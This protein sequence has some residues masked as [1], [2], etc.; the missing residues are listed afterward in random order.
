M[1]EVRK[2]EM[3]TDLLFDALDDGICIAIKQNNERCQNPAHDG[4]S[5][6]G[7][8]SHRQQ[9]EQLVAEEENDHEDTRQTQGSSPE[10]TE[11]AVETASQALPGGVEAADIHARDQ[12]GKMIPPFTGSGISSGSG[13]RWPQLPVAR[14]PFQKLQDSVN[15][16]SFTQERSHTALQKRQD[17]L[18]HKID[19]IARNDQRNAHSF[20]ESLGHH[21]N[22]IEVLIKSYLDRLA[23][24][25]QHPQGKLRDSQ[26]KLERKIDAV[27]RND[28]ELV[29]HLTDTFSKHHDRIDV[30]LKTNLEKLST[31]YQQSHTML[32][33][34]HVGLK[35]KIDGVLGEDHEKLKTKVDKLLRNDQGIVRTLIKR[36]D[37]HDSQFDAAFKHHFDDLRSQFDIAFQHHFDNCSARHQ[38]TE[39]PIRAGYTKLNEKIDAILRH[40]EA[41]IQEKIDGALRNDYVKLAQKIDAVLREDQRITETLTD[42]LADH[43]NQI[44][45]LAQSHSAHEEALNKE[46]L[47]MAEELT[48]FEALIRDFCVQMQV[49]QPGN[50]AAKALRRKRA[51]QVCGR[52][53]GPYV[54][55]SIANSLTHSMSVLKS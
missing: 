24:G 14:D 45:S 2:E 40:D 16:L 54:T 1:D 28:S 21:Y 23:A 36:F 15:A 33:Q 51:D 17:A 4:F 41:M 26:E 43:R 52:R 32:H 31:S 25:H 10:T 3:H 30:T 13:L 11:S 39:M 27:L 19:E 44:S 55:Q 49:A 35:E 7:I 50:E 42:G 53:P 12:P 6:C 18:E 29:R 38:H 37:D 20:N 22:Q 46:Y 47:V 5:T 8:A 48:N 34:D 9:E